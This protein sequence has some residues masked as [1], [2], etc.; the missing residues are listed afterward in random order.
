MNRIK[1]LYQKTSP[2]DKEIVRVLLIGIV[3][4]VFLSILKIVVGNSVHSTALQIDGINGFADVLS[5]LLTI[6]TMFLSN[7]GSDERHPMGYGR[8]EYLSSF[9][10]TLLVG[11]LGGRSI[12][13]SLKDLFIDDGPPSYDMYAMMTSIVSFFCKS[14]YGTYIIRKGNQIHSNSLIISGTDTRQDSFLS[15]GLLAAMVVEKLF[16]LDLEPYFSILIAA[17]TL[18]VAIVMLH[19][20]MDQLLGSSSDPEFV[21]QIKQQIIDEQGVE[22]VFNLVIHD[23]G[24]NNTLGSV[25]IEV[26]KDMKARDISLLSN[27]IIRKAQ[28][29]GLTLTSIG[30]SA[31]D[32]DDVH[33]SLMWDRILHL[34]SKDKRIL[35]AYAFLYDGK[36]KIMSFYILVEPG[37][38]SEEVVNALKQQITRVYPGVR[39]RINLCSA[40]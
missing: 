3:M 31:S 23:Y 6:V 32:P 13:I 37:A 36:E 26:D 14:V 25:N 34:V 10:V 39:V 18:Q 1:K 24:E 19:K 29:K 20:E 17:G 2:R 11:Y 5:F 28:E 16:G 15:I 9:M 27:R 7:K 35:R 33:D 30:I 21:K 4:N 38:D 12:I 22:N 8:I 40:E